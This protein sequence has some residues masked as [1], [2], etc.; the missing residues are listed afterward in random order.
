MATDVIDLEEWKKKICIIKS[1]KLWKKTVTK[2]YPKS[3]E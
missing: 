1:T 2:N 3:K